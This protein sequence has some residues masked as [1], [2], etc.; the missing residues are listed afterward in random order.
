MNSPCRIQYSAGARSGPVSQAF[1]KVTNR[2]LMLMD[3]PPT[4]GMRHV[5]ARISGLVAPVGSRI[6]RTTL[7]A[8]QEVMPRLSSTWLSIQYKGVAGLLGAN[9]AAYIF[10]NSRFMKHRGEDGLQRADRHF[11]ASRYNASNGRIWCVPLSLFNHGDSLVQLGLNCFALCM[12]GPA[13]EV[14]FGARVLVA[15]FLFCGTT[16]A[17]ME[18][19]MG[20]HWCRGSSAGITGLLGMGA[21]S[22]PFQ[23]LSIWGVLDVR[24]ASLALTIFGAELLVG[25]F[26]SGRSELAHVAHAGGIAAALPFLYYLKWFRK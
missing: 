12:V 10:L 1:D 6:G 11:I 20:N 25:L 7:R 3:T 18:M 21:L 5:N 17:V 8:C 19:M 16:G 24:A 4:Q 13:A 2:L 14:A 23:I 15:G 22:S 26:G 9:V